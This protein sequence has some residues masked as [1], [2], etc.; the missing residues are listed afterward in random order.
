MKECAAWVFDEQKSIV[1]VH[2]E[3]E[4]RKPDPRKK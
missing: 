1:L 4:L 3:D 2:E